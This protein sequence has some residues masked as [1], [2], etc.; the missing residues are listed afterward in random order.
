MNVRR[1][2]AIAGLLVW[3]AGLP[4]S[5]A[6]AA[7][8]ASDTPQSSDARINALIARMT[9]EEKVGQLSLYGPADV[10]I[11]NNPQAGLRNGRQEAA[12]VRAGRVT[13]LFNNAGLEGKL[14]LQQIA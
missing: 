2:S 8:A 9:V 4:F 5:P 11:P 12:D 1:T 6:V 7:G 3:L 13:G 10:N 14:R